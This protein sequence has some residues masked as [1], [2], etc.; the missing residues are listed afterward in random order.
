MLM[1]I[2]QTIIIP[3]GVRVLLAL[4]VLFVGRWLA[5]NVQRWTTASLQKTG[6]TASFVILIT[7]LSYYGTLILTGVVILAVLGVPTATLAAIVGIV[8]VVLAISLQ[9]SLGNLAATIIFLL[10]KPFQIGDV[11]ETGGVLGV[12]QEIQMFHTT[13]ISPDGK[14][15]I[16]PNGNIQSSGLTNYSKTNR[17]RINLSFGIDYSSDIDQAKAILMKLLEADER[18]LAEPAARVFVHELADSS[19]NLVAWPFVT[20]EDYLTFQT[21]F[22]EQVKKA[23]D[24]AGIVMP[25]PQQDVHLFTHNNVEELLR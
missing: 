2:F 24:Q 11:I 9:Q 12:V 17:I 10:F 18:V 8:V 3:F 16:L 6:L 15:H 7:A 4:L 23:F 22:V 5:R 13:L 14:T 19:I 1:N 21:Y 20:V 25:F